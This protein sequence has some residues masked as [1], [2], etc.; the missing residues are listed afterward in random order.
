MSFAAVLTMLVM[1][2]PTLA[3]AAAPSMSRSEHDCCLQMSGHCGEMAKQGCCQIKVRNDLQELPVH[4]V[5]APVLP[6]VTVALLYP[7]LIKLPITGAHRWDAPEDHSP[8]GLLIACT[9]VLRI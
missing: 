7:L 3:C 1:M 6:L 8:P 5:V 4:V 2:L 9:T